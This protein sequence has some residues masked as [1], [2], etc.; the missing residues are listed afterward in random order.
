V[1]VPAN[2]LNHGRTTHYIDPSLPE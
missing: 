2:I 1:H